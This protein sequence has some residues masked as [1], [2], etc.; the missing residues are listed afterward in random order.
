[1]KAP[2]RGNLIRVSIRGTHST[3][4][5]RDRDVRFF[6][7]ALPIFSFSPTIQIRSAEQEQR[8]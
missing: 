8:L 5:L 2:E 6:F 3:A 4:E 1:M 7:Q